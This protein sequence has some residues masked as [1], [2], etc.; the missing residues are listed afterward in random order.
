MTIQGFGTERITEDLQ[1]LMPELRIMRFDQ[2]STKQKNAFRNLLN[3]FEAG[4]ADVMVGTQ[5]AVKGLDY[6][7]VQL[8][9]VINADHLLNFPDFRSHERTFQ[10]LHQLSGRAGRHG[11]QGE[12]IIQ[13]RQ[14]NHPILQNVAN[15]D[16]LGF[17]QQQIIERELFNYAPFS[18]MIKL[19]LKH[20]SPD[21]IQVASSEFSKL[22]KQQLGSMVLGPETPFVSK[23]RNL[24]IR[25]LLI[26]IDAEKNNPSSIKEFIEKTFDFL[27]Q[28]DNIKGL[29]LIAD[30]DPQ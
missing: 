3:E 15:D 7:N 30:V 2:D 25:N 13:T 12:M 20:K 9:A 29:Q 27:V 28:R 10:L 23:I 22:L 6:G 18:K 5:I 19:T 11:R 16:Y 1:N 4:A 26:K 17:Y 14:V 8:T 24:Y 21:E